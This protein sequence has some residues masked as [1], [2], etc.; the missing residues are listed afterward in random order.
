MLSS[1]LF[2]SQGHAIAASMGLEEGICGV[3]GK[4]GTPG[5]W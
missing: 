5:I 4:L 1:G 3:E 2:V